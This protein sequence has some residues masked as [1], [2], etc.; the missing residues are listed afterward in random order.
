MSNSSR[1][2]TTELPDVRPRL[3][4]LQSVGRPV[5]GLAFWAAIALPFLHLPLLITGLETTGLTA[6]FLLLLGLNVVALIVGQ[7][8]GRD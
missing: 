6:A 2:E 5:I 8:Y 7:P 3:A 1:S 4:P